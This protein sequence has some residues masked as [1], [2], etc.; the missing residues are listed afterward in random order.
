M[1]HQG[2]VIILQVSEIL[3]QLD[4]LVLDKLNTCGLA[5]KMI[6]HRQLVHD[7]DDFLSQF[8]DLTMKGLCVVEKLKCCS[9]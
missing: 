4:S 1:T 7:G 2:I 8:L 3:Q 5:C 9:S 6:G